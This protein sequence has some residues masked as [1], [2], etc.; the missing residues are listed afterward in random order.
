MFKVGALSSA[1]GKTKQNPAM[2]WPKI[3]AAGMFLE[4]HPLV[5]FPSLENV[6][7]AQAL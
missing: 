1:E 6:E 7:W 4:V 2:R 5:G 3:L